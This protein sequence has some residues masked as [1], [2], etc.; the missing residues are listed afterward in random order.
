[1]LRRSPQ[2]L[3]IG[4]KTMGSL[5]SK[6][7]LFALDPHR[8]KR[9]RNFFSMGWEF[10]HVGASIISLFK[11]MMFSPFLTFDLVD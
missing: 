4:P 5:D 7:Y 9:R 11:G 2:K 8:L 6:T 3:A 1:M 10:S